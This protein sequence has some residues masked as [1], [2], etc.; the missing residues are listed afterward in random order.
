M[1]VWKYS[2]E[3]AAWSS[4]KFKNTT[5]P[6]RSNF[7]STKL[8][9]VVAIFGGHGEKGYLNDLYL[10]NLSTMSSIL[11][12]ASS[13]IIP[14]PRQAAC[15]SSV[16]G[17]LFIFGGITEQDISEEL[18]SYDISTNMFELYSSNAIQPPKSAFSQCS[19]E[20]EEDEIVFY[21]YFGETSGETP[22]STVYKYILSR[23]IWI[24]VRNKGYESEFSRSDSKIFKVDNKLIIVGGQQW[25]TRA[26]NDIQEL[27]LTDGTF[28]RLGTLPCSFYNAGG[29][30]YKDDIYIFG[31]GN[32]FG[33]VSVISVPR[34]IFI[35]ISLNKNCGE[36]CNWP[37][38]FG[39]K[40]K[41]ENCEACE[42]G[43]YSDKLE[44]DMCNPCPKGTYGQTKGAETQRQ[45]YPCPE[46]SFSDNEGS[47]FCKDCAETEKCLV[48]TSTPGKGYFSSNEISSSQPKAYKT[49][50]GINSIVLTTQLAAL[51][52]CVFVLII[53]ISVNRLRNA[54]DKIDMFEECHNY[55]SEQFMKLRTTKIGGVFTI[56]YL[57]IA[58]TFIAISIM[59]FYLDNIEEIKNL[60]PSIILEDDYTI[61]KA[62]HLYINFMFEN[63]GGS[64]NGDGNSLPV[65]KTNDINGRYKIQRFLKQD[66]NCYI[67]IYFEEWSLSYQGNVMVYIDEENSYA[68]AIFANITSSSSIPDEFSSMSAY[69]L[70]PANTIFKGFEPTYINLLATPSVFL[71]DSN[72]WDSELTGYHVALTQDPILGS[73]I[74]ISEYP[75]TSEIKIQ[76]NFQ[77]DTSVLITHRKFKQDVLIMMGSA[78][79]AI[80]GFLELVQVVMGKVEGNYIEY[81]KKMKRIKRINRIWDKNISLKN[82]LI[83]RVLGMPT[84]RSA[85]RSIKRL[86]RSSFFLISRNPVLN[87]KKKSLLINANSEL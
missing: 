78:L 66:D 75:Y 43:Y 13:D 86:R 18:W 19:A 29:V 22:L 44:H 23:K 70:P 12:E 36:K 28:T 48:G 5:P 42:A 14:S 8:G 24:E 40:R 2:I 71:S 65:I 47:S 51:F 62:D 26:L 60:V 59:L 55:D 38:S 16:D 85:T 50:E 10:L 83:K 46:N 77:K 31:G 63:Y 79:G 68:S 37:C 6:P 73:Y 15:M 21:V 81:A 20:L 76:V 58:V 80:S 52:S 87:A 35:K 45:C 53:F 33:A 61:N 41:G 72:E 74:E 25:N 84:Y 4:T 57:T 30:Y 39:S 3:K 56:I 27:N 7:A 11:I 49:F 34:N 17:Y 67:D 69:I 54:L 82:T 64:C 1:D 9:D 32:S